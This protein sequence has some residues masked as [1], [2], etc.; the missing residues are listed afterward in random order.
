MIKSA[1]LK[2]K[3]KSTLSLG[4]LKNQLV[5]MTIKSASALNPQYGRGD[6]DKAFEKIK[7]VMKRT[8]LSIGT[9][10]ETFEEYDI[11]YNDTVA[12]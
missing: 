3:N 5:G 11:K 10:T 4:K 2:V 7:S 9:I 6:N 1:L 12:L 8:N